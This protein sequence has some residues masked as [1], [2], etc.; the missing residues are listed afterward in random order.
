MA[1][2]L[3]KVVWTECT[4]EVKQDCSKFVNRERQKEYKKTCSE[5]GSR[6][7][8]ITKIDPVKAAILAVIVLAILGGGGLYLRSRMMSGVTPGYVD[9]QPGSSSGG[10][11][12][13]D[14]ADLT[15]S[16]QTRRQGASGRLMPADF[17]RSG[18]V[19]TA[20]EPFTLGDR[21]RVDVSYRKNAKL[22][23]FYR[24]DSAAKNLTV[25]ADGHAILPSANDW[26]ELDDQRGTEEF[27]L[28]S[29]RQ[30][31]A[32]LET[33]GDHFSVTALDERLKGLGR[34]SS[35]VLIRVPHR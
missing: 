27:V 1:S 3:E 5:C 19:Y 4:G 25:D 33:I 15:W 16:L 34:G 31:I 7:K 26:F 21:L 12:T 2:F 13:P 10:T 35:M 24:N 30:P 23:A 9:A 28:V 20:R 32:D 29:A 6:V 18:N 8:E 14:A 11:A 17:E 22:Y